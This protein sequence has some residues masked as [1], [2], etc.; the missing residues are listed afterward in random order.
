[1]LKLVEEEFALLTLSNN[2]LEMIRIVLLDL[3]KKN[4]DLTDLNIIELKED[5][6]YTSIISN[7]FKLSDWN[8]AKFT[9][10]YVKKNEDINFVARCWLE[11]AN[12]QKVWKKREK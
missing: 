12:I 9:S 6:R 8:I 1:M 4:G 11:A 10:Q 7:I 5:I 2:D 3:Y